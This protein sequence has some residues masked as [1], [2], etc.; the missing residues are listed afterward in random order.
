MLDY[1]DVATQMEFLEAQL[2]AF[3][4][5]GDEPN[6]ALIRNKL[7]LLLLKQMLKELILLRQGKKP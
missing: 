7:T 6:A 1:K 4:R 2:N 3:E 5:R